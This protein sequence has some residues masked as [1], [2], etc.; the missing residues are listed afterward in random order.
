M[1]RKKRK[2]VPA[3]RAAKFDKPVRP[4]PPGVR[5]EDLKPWQLIKFIDED[6]E[7]LHLVL[8]SR[9]YKSKEGRWGSFVPTLRL[10]GPNLEDN[11]GESDMLHCDMNDWNYKIEI[12]DEAAFRLQA[13][14]GKVESKI[15]KPRQVKETNSQ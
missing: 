10:S 2:L 5:V 4:K 12:L 9:F 3:A 8:P 14:N 7:E 6:Q 1:A 13:F 15:F 11:C